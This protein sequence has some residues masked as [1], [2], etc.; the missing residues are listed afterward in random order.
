MRVPHT[1]T[2]RGKRVKIILRNGSE[3]VGKFLDRTDRWVELDTGRV[4]K[5]D[6][7]SF[8]IIKGYKDERP[9]GPS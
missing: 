4:M 7:R 9:D 3:L 8:I 2:R 5:S 6:I 1:A